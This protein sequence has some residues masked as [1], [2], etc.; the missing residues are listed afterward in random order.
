MARP[1]PKGPKAHPTK[2]S[3]IF[4]VKVMRFDTLAEAEAELAKAEARGERAFIQPPLAAWA[5]RPDS[6]GEQ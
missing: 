6:G 2:W 1:K 4:S 3:L 5:G